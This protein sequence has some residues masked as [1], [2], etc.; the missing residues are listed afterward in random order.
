MVITRYR[1][2]VPSMRCVVLY[3]VSDV[4]RLESCRSFVC[5]DFSEGIHVEGKPERQF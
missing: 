2:L 1:D 4:A 5:L 3:T